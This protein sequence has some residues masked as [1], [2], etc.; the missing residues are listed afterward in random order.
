MVAPVVIFVCCGVS[1]LLC[2]CFLLGVY[3]NWFQ[4]F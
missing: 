2:G 1:V 4:V 3:N